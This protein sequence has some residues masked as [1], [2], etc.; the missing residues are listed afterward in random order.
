[1]RLLA[2]VLLESLVLCAQ[3]DRLTGYPQDLA[4]VGTGQA[5]PFS[6]SSSFCEARSQLLLR[7]ARLPGPGASLVGIEVTSINGGTVTYT[8]LQIR[9]SPVPPTASRSFALNANLPAPTTIVQ[10]SNQTIAWPL[11]SW[12]RL[13]T[14]Q[15]YVHDG[16]SDLTI[17]IQKLAV[18]GHSTGGTSGLLRPDLDLMYADAG[19]AGSGLH[20]SNQVGFAVMAIDLRLVWR[21]AP[22]SRLR[23]PIPAAGS[24]GFAIGSTLD[25]IVAATP[26]S[27]FV[28]L[29]DFQVSAPSSFPP[30]L[31]LW[32]VQG[33]VLQFHSVAG[34]GER[35][36]TLGIPALPSLVG[37]PLAFQA[38]VSDAVSG[39]IQWTNA[40]DCLI[41]P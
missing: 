12:H 13:A 2:A 33:A 32:R 30:I 14:T 36:L 20:L 8:S 39:S 29:G 5:I 1:M 27:P 9:V 11:N 22:T 38:V 19:P 24:H 16:V 7:A 15:P 10:L 17:D 34:N 18:A 28:L 40:S 35:N 25:H 23:S 26:G 31:G 4:H 6:N 21:D 41:G 37:Q 3:N